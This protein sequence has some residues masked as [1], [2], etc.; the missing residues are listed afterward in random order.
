[1]TLSEY[2]YVDLLSQHGFN[3][4]NATGFSSTKVF[5]QTIYEAKKMLR[6]G[7][8]EL[9]GTDPS[10]AVKDV[11]SVSINRRV[12]RDPH[13]ELTAARIPTYADATRR[14]IYESDS[15]LTTFL[16]E[17]EKNFTTLDKAFAGLSSEEVSY[18]SKLC[19]LA[20][21]A[22]YSHA[23]ND[24]RTTQLLLEYGYP[25]S[26][27]LGNQELFDAIFGQLGNRITDVRSNVNTNSVSSI[28]SK[29]DDDK[30]I[31]TYE[32]DY[33]EDE[34]SAVFTPGSVYYVASAVKP[35]A[36][37]NAFSIE[38]PSELV[39][40][41]SS[42]IDRYSNFI[43][44]FNILPRAGNI[45]F[46]QLG[47]SRFA[48][49]P[50]MMANS[51]YTLFVNDSTGYVKTDVTNNPV[52]DLLNEAATHS[53]LR[54]NLLLYV[55]M[56]TNISGDGLV[57]VET[58]GVDLRP[59]AFDR[60]AKQEAQNARAGSTID[61]LIKNCVSYIKQITNDNAG[62][63]KLENA[64]RN[65]NE[66]GPLSRALAF[67][68]A[69]TDVYKTSFNAGYTRYSHFSDMHM[70]ALALQVVLDSARRY[71]YTRNRVSPA[72]YLNTNF[73]S[74]ATSSPLLATKVSP[75]IQ[76]LSKPL[77]VK[78]LGKKSVNV[79]QSAYIA[80]L[81]SQT[82]N[83]IPFISKLPL[84]QAVLARLDREDTL[85][86][87]TVMAPLNALRVMR[88]QLKEYVLYLQKPEN[89]NVINDILG[90]VGDAKHVELLADKGQVRLLYDTV[91]TV[92]Q[93]IS[94]TSNN[95]AT[96]DI[97]DVV[98][99][100]RTGA[101]AD[102]LRVFDDSF[103][104]SMSSNLLKAAFA[105]AKFSPEQGKNIR[106]LAVGLPHGFTTQLQNKF[107]ISTFAEQ[108]RSRRK[109]N[110]VFVIDVYKIDVR[111]PDLIFKP[112]PKVFEL[113][114]F[115]VRDERQYKPT[116][117]GAPLDV[118]LDSIPTRDYSTFANDTND[119]LDSSYDFMT[120]DDKKTLT[121]N[122]TMSYLLELYYRLLTGIPLSERELYIQ[123]PDENDRPPP[124]VAKAIL[125]NTITTTFKQPESSSKLDLS[126]IARQKA[127]TYAQ[128]LAPKPSSSTGLA[129][130]NQILKPMI[131][132]DFYKLYVN[133]QVET[134]KAT[135]DAVNL[136]AKKKTVYTDRDIA[137]KYMM[138]PKLF[139]RVFFV[140]VDP[141]DYE[142]DRDE[143][144]KSEVGKATF[145][146]LLNAGE[147]EIES[148]T[149]NR[150]TR[151]AYYLK[152]HRLEK[153]MTFEKYFVVVRAYTPLTTR[154]R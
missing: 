36:T 140:D 15:R 34:Q 114:R 73:K 46:N 55:S 106:L 126:F 51:L 81:Q 135:A 42:I 132:K 49:D 20:R 68:K 26:T 17:L 39:T 108:V 21:E 12:Y 88:D 72:M 147:I 24:N 59:T 136:L 65:F 48:F 152:D 125:S 148:E 80:P 105:T 71:A 14:G 153:Q 104:T 30:A 79:V 128:S 142:I 31:L 95:A 98:S 67:I 121:R 1:V 123:D 151:D 4:S 18:T 74:A 52:T 154:T 122:T 137:A 118:V 130:S 119:T 6:A 76:Q 111:Y 22:S 19:T 99:L 62:A 16:Q 44:Q 141:D 144:F 32:I 35:N 64:L 146:Q 63:T 13:V 60:I 70:T 41:A 120:T 100:T 113:S 103:I 8:D 124:F 3:K 75:T 86:I 69:A 89:V 27:E 47:N 138:S 84:K 7:S 57:A 149:I 92:L 53:A 5:L 54:A 134:A 9:V 127:I 116:Q 23:L 28:A 85:L 90:V 101:P 61:K 25:I 131:L 11:D 112:I 33:L 110:D 40:R 87:R 37:A 43:N 145:A 29:I 102:D 10:L 78:Y 45:K 139:E 66:Q 133:K 93:R 83:V 117:V 58:Q 82:M 109:Q 96:T 150:T 129:I 143:T 50:A 94:P 77:T 56:V 115:P 38:R 107:K 91:E 97:T 2:T